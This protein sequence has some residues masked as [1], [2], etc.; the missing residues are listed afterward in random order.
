MVTYNCPLIPIDTISH[1][2]HGA[3][4][5]HDSFLPN[6]RGGNPLFWQVINNEDEIGFSIHYLK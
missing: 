1:V 4:N 2:S 5:L 6:Y 3:I